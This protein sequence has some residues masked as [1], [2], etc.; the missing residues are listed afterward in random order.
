MLDRVKYTVMHGLHVEGKKV[1]IAN[2]LISTC[3]AHVYTFISHH[4]F[5]IVIHIIWL[6]CLICMCTVH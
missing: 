2:G 5:V 3:T 1:K 6:A 4:T